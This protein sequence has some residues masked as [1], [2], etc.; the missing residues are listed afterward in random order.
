MKTSYI[1]LAEH[2][3]YNVQTNYACLASTLVL[4]NP[5]SQIHFW[6]FLPIWK[7]CAKPC[8]IL[9]IR[10]ISV[11]QYYPQQPSKLI[12][13]L[14]VFFFRKRQMVWEGTGHLNSGNRLRMSLIFPS[15]HRIFWWTTIHSFLNIRR[16]LN[17]DVWCL[18]VTEEIPPS[19]WKTAI[20]T[21]YIQMMSWTLRHYDEAFLLRQPNWNLERCYF[22]HDSLTCLA[23][24]WRSCRR[25]RID[26]YQFLRKSWS[27]GKG[28]G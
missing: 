15:R 10:I 4:E 11:T 19:R 6:H 21:G 28:R 20:I 13:P 26:I 24:R 7:H 14:V 23:C 9:W 18:T 17:H 22:W 27:I 8:S 5:A 2:H 25:P 3:D 12:R 1:L 16:D